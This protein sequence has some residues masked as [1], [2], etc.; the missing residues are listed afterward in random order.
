[1]AQERT[2]RLLPGEEIVRDV[3]G[4]GLSLILTSIR[5]VQQSSTAWGTRSGSKSFFLENLDSIETKT[6]TH[7]RLLIAAIVC[8]AFSVLIAAQAGRVETLQAFAAIFA[9][10]AFACFL[11]Y[12]LLRTRVVAFHSHRTDI[13]IQAKGRAID[14]LPAFIEL[15]ERVKADRV[16]LLSGLTEDEGE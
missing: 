15:V 14:T 13:D 6:R 3:G 7:P 2:I 5:L 8:L 11:A 4:P 16:H 9:V 10:A 12:F 1:M